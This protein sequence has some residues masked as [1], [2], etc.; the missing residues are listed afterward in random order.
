MKRLLWIVRDFP[1]DCW[2][3]FLNADPAVHI[4][5]WVAMLSIA[6]LIILS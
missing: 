6:V 2:D 1:R 3:G 4:V 5:V